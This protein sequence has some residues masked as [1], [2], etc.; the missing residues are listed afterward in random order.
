MEKFA[1]K[2]KKGQIVL[3]VLLALIPWGLGMLEQYPCWAWLLWLASLVL[4][5][6]VLF[7]W[8]KNSG[9]IIQ[10]LGLLVLASG[11]ILFLRSAYKSIEWRT[12]LEVIYLRPGAALNGGRLWTLHPMG[13]I[14]HPVFNLT[15]SISDDALSKAMAKEP[16]ENKRIQMARRAD[17]SKTILEVDPDPNGGDVWIEKHLVQPIA[18]KEQQYSFIASYRVKGDR[19]FVMREILK[20]ANDKYAARVVNDT[21][22][23]VLIE[24]KDSGFPDDPDFNGVTAGCFP[25]FISRRKHDLVQCLGSILNLSGQLFVFEVSGQKERVCSIPKGLCVPAIAGAR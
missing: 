5:L 18:P 10:I 13:R 20:I 6:H 3:S 14:N 15:Y 22:K 4:G 2:H 24:C 23:D 11:L 19:T 8:L 17:L 25:N 9:R 7:G 12:R 1:G 21:T 16:D